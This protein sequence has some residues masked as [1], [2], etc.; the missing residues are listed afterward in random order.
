[1]SPDDR[2]LV[3][4]GNGVYTDPIHL[5]DVWTGA[6]RAIAHADPAAPKRPRQILPLHF[7]AAGRRLAWCD[8][9]T[10]FHRWALAA[11]PRTPAPALESAGHTPHRRRDRGRRDRPG[12]GRPR[13]E[14]AGP[15]RRP[16]RCGTVVHDAAPR[17]HPRGGGRRPVARPRRGR[18]HG[19]G[20]AA[21][22][23]Q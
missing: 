3:T 16:H 17:L 7:S 11:A 19:P 15:P 9:E 10:R 6:E 14:P 1:F 4:S 13:P 21:R 12:A 23:A 5:V 8:S 18:R 22:A 20:V 2:L